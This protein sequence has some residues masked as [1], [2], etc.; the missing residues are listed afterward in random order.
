MSDFIQ[1]LAVRLV[2]GVE[3]IQE[4][5]D[6]LPG[7][8]RSTQYI[9][10]VLKELK[11]HL[12]VHP[13]TDK[14]AEIHYFKAVAPPLY[15]RLFY[16]DKLYEAGLERAH[17]GQEPLRHYIELELAKIEQ[18]HRRHDEFAH[19]YAVS[20][21][22]MD[23]RVFIRDARENAMLDSVE[24]IMGDVFCVG[25]YWA[26]QIWANQKIRP[27][28]QKM[29]HELDH[30]ATTGQATLIWTDSPTDLVELLMALHE[31]KSFNHGKTT[32]KELADWVQFHWGIEIRYFH[33]TWQEISR[34]KKTLT[35]YLDAARDRLLQK[36]EEAL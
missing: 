10:G 15:G 14:T 28:L 32:I 20:E 21:T 23:D 8:Y 25:C 36:H 4:Q 35:K 22:Y 1:E 18:F 19:Y 2:K 7:L 11:D 6:G 27:Y 31:M 16:Y 33:N 34:R 29:L 13:F 3:E 17:A 24:V 30:P 12:R 5:E 9:K 26:A